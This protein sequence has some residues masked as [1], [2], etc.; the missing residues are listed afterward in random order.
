MPAPLLN[1]FTLP[2]KLEEIERASTKKAKQ[3]VIRDATL[4]RW[5]KDR[6]LEDMVFAITAYST[7]YEERLVGVSSLYNSISK[8]IHRL[9]AEVLRQLP[10]MPAE[11]S[12][13]RTNK[14]EDFMDSPAIPYHMKLAALLYKDT[15][16][17]IY[18]EQV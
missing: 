13:Y 17:E 4:N 3:A 16:K 2:I 9:P 7:Y 12:T 10:P 8:I 18:G 1:A 15:F 5:V 14:Y 6:T 11:T